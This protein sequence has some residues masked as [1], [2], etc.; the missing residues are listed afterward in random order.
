MTSKSVA[1]LTAVSGSI[2]TG[3]PA[4]PAEAAQPGRATL[5]PLAAYGT[6]V[7]HVNLAWTQPDVD[8]WAV[9]AKGRAAMETVV[10]AAPAALAMVLFMDPPLDVM[11]GGAGQAVADRRH[12]T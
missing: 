1:E 7:P 6:S 11:A 12:G 3:A 4:L 2:R 8:A 5:L 10:S 9:V